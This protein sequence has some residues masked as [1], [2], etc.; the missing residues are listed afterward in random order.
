MG[1]YLQLIDLNLD[2]SLP[3]NWVAENVFGIPKNSLPSGFRV[4]P[5]P[6][7]GII[8]VETMCTSSLL[9]QSYRIVNMMGQTVMNGS[10]NGAET[11]CTSSLQQRIDVSKLP[12]GLYYIGIDGMT[13][14][15][16][17]K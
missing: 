1:A 6:T 4:F 9:Q 12:A 16:I 13:Q 17:V 7:D 10:L 2:N 8:L 15:L 3:E 14:K 5:N 11:M